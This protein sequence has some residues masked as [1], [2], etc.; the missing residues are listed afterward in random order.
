VPIVVK[1]DWVCEILSKNRNRDL[2][3]KKRIYHAHQVDHYWI[4]DPVN[5][6]LSVQRWHADGYVEVLIAERGE[7]VRAEPFG[8]IELQVGVLF[9]DDPAE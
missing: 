1:P 9:G 4:V 3:K 6:T 2:V 7:R 5:E 8:A